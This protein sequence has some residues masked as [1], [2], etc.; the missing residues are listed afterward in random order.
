MFAFEASAKNLQW[1]ISRGPMT[2]MDK[3]WFIRFSEK[4]GEARISLFTGDN[5]LHQTVSSTSQS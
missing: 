4:T 3:R 5:K 1:Y 2:K